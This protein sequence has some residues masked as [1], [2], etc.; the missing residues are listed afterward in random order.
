MTRMTLMLSGAGI[1]TL[2]L[3]LGG[4]ALAAPH[5]GHHHG[6][7]P[8]GAGASTSPEVAP[9]ERPVAMQYITLP[10]GV[11]EAVLYDT[12]EVVRTE[13]MEIWKP[14]CSSDARQVTALDLVTWADTHE[15][16]FATA[17]PGDITIID[18]GGVA[19]G[20][21]IIFTLGSSVP[22]AAIAS[23]T[24]IE[25]YL[26]GLFADPIT[27]TISVSYQAMGSGILG[28]TS[29]FYTSSTYTTARNGLINGQDG[30]DTIQDSLPTGSTCPV[31]YN[32][33]SSTVSQEGT[34][35]WTR[36]NYRATVGSV[37][38]NAASMTFNTQFSWDY[39]P[40]NGVSNY[41]F[42][43]VLV[44]EVGHALGFV[45]R[46]DYG[47]SVTD[48]TSLDLFRFQTTDGTG[49]YN[50]DTLAEW[51]TKARLVDYNTPN[52]AHHTDLVSVEY[53]MSDGTPY[54]ASHFREQ[55][56]NIGIMDP[57]FA[58]GQTF[59]PN[60]M[61]ASDLAVFDAIGYDR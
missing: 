55:T 24:A 36:A 6:A 31:R 42:R 10:A 12:G 33:N 38:G 58:A 21:N 39:D 30:D 19:G 2:L 44:H 50:P 8:S 4:G 40:S 52:D 43:D 59:Y 9:A 1:S 11:E 22:S 29:T 45:S 61:K 41:S 53:K 23:F 15:T 14:I 57:A 34:V 13:W 51:Q 54:Q 60:Y 7:P 16:E 32:G 26:E 3:A 47:A 27:I 28:G 5:D 25:S 20:L 46:V 17:E 18:S 56:A 37:T 48:M 35:Y 49:D